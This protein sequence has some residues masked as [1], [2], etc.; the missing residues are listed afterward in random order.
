MGHLTHMMKVILVRSEHLTQ[1]P[2]ELNPATENEAERQ[3]Y[4]LSYMVLEIMSSIVAHFPTV[5]PDIFRSPFPTHIR[6]SR[7]KETALIVDSTLH[8]STQAMISEFLVCPPSLLRVPQRCLPCSFFLS[9]SFLHK[10]D[11]ANQI[12]MAPMPFLEYLAN[13]E[14]QKG[15]EGEGDQPPL[16]EGNLPPLPSLGISCFA[17]FCLMG[18]TLSF[19]QVYLPQQVFHSTIPAQ[20]VLFER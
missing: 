13:L 8:S 18:G 5:N 7:E 11:L 19:P 9:S 6:A 4:L 2:R 16:T 14:S 10:Q 17:F 12:H 3:H 20:L 15:E 1:T